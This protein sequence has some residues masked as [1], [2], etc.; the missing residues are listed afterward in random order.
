MQALIE[1]DGIFGIG[2]SHCFW[3]GFSATV[4]DATKPFLSETGYR[5]FLGIYAEAVSGLS[6]DA[7]VR[8]I[9]VRHIEDNLNGKLI[10]VAKRFASTAA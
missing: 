1:M 9:C 7:F 2:G 3:P 4:V 10:P 6:P 5:S 8:E